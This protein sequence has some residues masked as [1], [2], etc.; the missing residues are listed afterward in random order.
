M[1]MLLHEEVQQKKWRA[2]AAAADEEDMLACAHLSVACRRQSRYRAVLSPEILVS[3]SPPP[4]LLMMDERHSH[5][6]V[7]ML[8]I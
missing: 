5:A 1:L 7:A 3:P 2:A 4:V 8:L 6:H